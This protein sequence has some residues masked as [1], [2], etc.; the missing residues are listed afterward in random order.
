MSSPVPGFI[1]AVAPALSGAIVRSPEWRRSFCIAAV[2][3]FAT[4]AGCAGNPA[5]PATE[6]D[7]DT[8]EPAFVEPAPTEA[9]IAAAKQQAEKL[10]KQDLTPQVL[11]EFLVAEVAAQRGDFQTAAQA[12]LDITR[13]TRDPRVARRAVE[14]ARAGGLNDLAIE[15]AGLWLEIEP[16][17]R[18]ALGTFAAVTVRAG[19]PDDAVQQLQR[20]LALDPARRPET[21]VQIGRLLSSSPDKAAG[22]RVMRQLAVDYPDLAEAHF[23]VAQTALAAGSDDVALAEVRKAAELRPGWELAALFEAQILQRK[24]P[25][26]A[27]DHLAKFLDRYPQSQDVRLGYA[28]LLV[29]ERRYPDARVQFQKLS[30]AHPQDTELIYA[31]AML[32]MQMEDWPR[33]DEYLRRLLELPYHDRNSV[34]MYLGQVAQERKRYDDA[35]KWYR[36]VTPGERYLQA[37]I[38]QAQVLA[39]KGDIDGARRMLQPSGSNSN[40]ERVQLALA[41]SQVLRDANRPKDAYAVVEAALAA[42][43]DDPDLLYERAMIADK[44]DRADI[45]ESSLRK[46]IALKPDHAHA[47]NALGYSL[48]DRNERL[49]EARAL[50]EKALSLAPNDPFIVDS[51]GWVLY[52]QGDLHGAL[53]Q[54]QRAYNERPDPEIAAHLGEVLW[55]LGRAPEAEKIWGEAAAKSPSNEALE[56]TVRRFKQ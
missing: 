40:A 43:P 32:S 41:E 15:S 28:R 54:L 30:E 37:R 34:R 5:T 13:R 16:D 45:L 11:Y 50:I 10:P 52:R 27:I 8:D 22:L 44:L 49:P 36:A 1:E 4:L 56:K 48:A 29:G 18:E 19:H 55:K 26:A 33:A 31:V 42:V 3:A 20:I 46:L 17:S 23:A 47:Y 38:R 25:A 9:E 35:L 21:L 2:L 39:L 12:Y 24:S 53:R 51:M 6:T 14:V 7:A